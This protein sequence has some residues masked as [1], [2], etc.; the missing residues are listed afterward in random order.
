MDLIKQLNWRY[1]AKRMNG[2]KVDANKI[3][4]I[5][6]ATRLAASGG[7]LQPYTI[8]MIENENLRKQINQDICKQPQIMEAS[9]L[10]VFCEFPLFA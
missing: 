7:G 2:K 10:L 9:H 4:V 6:E 3:D 1:A 8:L 5:L